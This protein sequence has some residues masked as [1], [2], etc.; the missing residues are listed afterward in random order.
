M[1]LCAVY[2]RKSEDK[3]AS[4]DLIKDALTLEQ[5]SAIYWKLR[6][7]GYTAI[8]TGSLKKEARA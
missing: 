4:L 5:A 7:K 8:I 2:A 6:K 1:K 3:E